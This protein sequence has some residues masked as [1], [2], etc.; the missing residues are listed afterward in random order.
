[1]NRIIL[2]GNLVRDP[3]ALSTSG[4][5]NFTRFSIAVNRP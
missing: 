5:V 3:E 4:G 1:M 2:T